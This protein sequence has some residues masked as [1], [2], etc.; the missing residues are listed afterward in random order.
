MHSFNAYTTTTTT[1]DD[2]DDDND[3]DDKVTERPFSTEPK[4]RTTNKQTKRRKVQT[5]NAHTLH[6]QM[7]H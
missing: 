2:D 6:T 5:P 1:T 7:T 3:D 4:A